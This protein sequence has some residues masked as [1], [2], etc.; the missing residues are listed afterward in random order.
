[1]AIRDVWY[2]AIKGGDI[3]AIEGFGE[4]PYY[5]AT[6][7]AENGQLET[8]KWIRAHG[9]EWTYRAA[10]RAAENGHLDTLKWIRAHGGKWSHWAADWAACHGHLDT[11]KIVLNPQSRMR[12]IDSKSPHVARILLLLDHL[13]VYFPRILA[14][15]APRQPPPR[16]PQRPSHGF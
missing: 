2:N 4:I 5:A 7:A 1:M 8:L 9:G 6:Y 11:L 16:P 10:D 15:S 3:E 13:E 14:A 12:R